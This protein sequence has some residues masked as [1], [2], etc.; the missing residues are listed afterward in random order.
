MMSWLD[1]RYA[2]RTLRRSP[3]FTT[4]AILT[5]A[6]CSGADTAV[7]SVVNSVLLKPLPYP[8][9]DRL[10]AVWHA[11][12][13]ARLDYF[14]GR[15]PSS[16]SMFYTYT[17]E[18]RTFE[19]FG[20]WSPGLVSVTGVADPEQVPSVNVSGGLLE[21]LGVRPRLGRWFLAEDFDPNGAPAAMLTYDY[22]QRR[23]GG[24]ASAIGTTLTVDGR[25]AEIVG[26]MPQGFR[27]VDTAADILLPLRFDRGSLILPPFNYFGVARLKPGVT[28]ADANADIRRMLPTWMDSW[29]GNARFYADV[30]QIGPAVTALKQDVTGNI[31]NVLWVVMGTIAAVLLIACTNITNLLLVRAQ[32]REREFAVR[33][34]LGGGT[35]RIARGL[36][37][38]SLVLG[39]AGGV[40]GLLVA[41][42]GLGFLLAL[43]PAGL[44]RLGE[45]A[46]DGRAIAFALAVSL[47][48]GFVLGLAPALK[49]AAPRIATALRSGG[50]GMSQSRG[51]A[52]TQNLLVVAQV[53]L[54]LVLLVSS[55]LMIRTFQNLRSVEPGFTNAARL[56]TFRLSIPA[57]IEPDPQRVVL[58]EKQIVD[59][60]AAIPGVESAAF[61]S[62]IPM[63]ALGA[64][65]NSIGVDGRSTD[66]TEPAP[67]RRFKLVSPGFFATAGTRIVAG[68]DFTWAEID[69]G[70]PVAML[71]ENLARELFG[72]AAAALGERINGRGERWHE[73]IGVVQNVR[74][75]GVDQPPPTTAY[76][77][78]FTSAP[79]ALTGPVLRQLTVVLRSPLAGTDALVRQIERGVWSI[80]ADLPVAL[81]STM[82]E[83]YDRSLA[84][85]TFTLMMLA[86]A[87]AVALVLGVLGLY[88][89]LS[90]VV[91]Q[92]SREIAIRLALGAE[93]RHVRRTFV[94]HGLALAALGIVAGLAAAAAVTQLMTALLAEVGPLDPPTYAAAT[95]LLVVVAAVASLVPAWRA[96]TV[97]PAKAL[98]AD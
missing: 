85:T 14:G 35:W 45:I 71:S 61:A 86:T 39:V 57:E 73:V 9:S 16:A 24:Q 84:R 62:S 31:G 15:L 66:P 50:R 97:E 7:F 23:F 72:D 51:S 49:C 46:L 63:S 75:N 95:G 22:W 70:A 56:Q 42:A 37:L 34:A 3:L 76:W 52:R 27:V 2:L 91:S 1:F 87:G 40:L 98:A 8:G 79:S 44:P 20:L 59:A 94:R 12:P 29:E 74:D 58:M 17:Q 30:W 96:S 65:A 60:M 47:L 81:P 93:Q 6:I 5:L 36:M 48:A 77:P 13:G 68:R 69:D 26:I 11:A 18:N 41:R 92:R 90:Y 83:I 88:G 78:S 21:A 89:V 19:Q 10:V 28:V 55:G 54:A 33:A 43:A 64:M 53:A 38:E 82:Q 67:L 4:V 32:G 80:D 25:A